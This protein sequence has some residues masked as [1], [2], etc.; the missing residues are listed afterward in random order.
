LGA[1]RTAKGGGGGDARGPEPFDAPSSQ[2][3]Q[4]QEVPKN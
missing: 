2:V 4:G 3:L 1:A